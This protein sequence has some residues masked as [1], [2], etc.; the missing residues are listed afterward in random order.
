MI[1]WKN[2]KTVVTGA[3]GFIGSHLV[4]R[5]LDR[6]AD[7]TAFVRYNSS[8]SAGRLDD[9][10]EAARRRLRIVSGDIGELETVRGLLAGQDVV[11]HLAA[12]VGIPYSYVHPN[13]V[14]EVNTIGTLNVLTAAKDHGLH[15]VI[16]TSTSEV[17]GTALKVPI[18]ETHPKQPQSPYSA[19]KIAGDALALSFHAAF[20]A[21]VAIVRPFNT[22]GPRQSDRAI[23]PTIIS[24]AITRRE[25]VIGS[26]K[27]TRDFTYVTD[28]VEGMLRA[29]ECDECV[30]QEVNLGS[31]HEISIGDLAE[32]I[33]HMV[34]SDVTV[35]QSDERVR[36]AKS[37]VA[38]LLSSNAKMRQ[39]TGWQPNVT[40]DEGLRRT[41]E[42][43]R[44]HAELFDPTRYRI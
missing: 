16:V 4:E 36:P 32:R 3:A 23:I 22:Y 42:W 24:Q 21:P 25:I 11:F 18:D 34:G 37:E 38:R 31:G 12:L 9:I 14:V 39:L 35:R 40:L 44:Q 41:I 2:K 43:V 15:K 19:S 5:L 17:Y 6:G 33:K 10:D 27:P 20:G 26:L 8:N 28:T 29:A 30:G 7:V 1:D 13:E